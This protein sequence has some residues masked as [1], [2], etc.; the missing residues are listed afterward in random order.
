MKECLALVFAIQKTRYYLVGQTIHVIF[1][2]NP[3]CIL[4]TKLG[5][6]TSRLAK[7]AIL[8]S[9]YDIRFVPQKAVKAQALPDFLKAHL[10]SETSKLRKDIPD[11][12]F[13]SNMISEDEVWPIF[14][15]GASRIG[16]KGKIIAGGGYFSHHKIM[17]FL[18]HFHWQHLVLTM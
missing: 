2:V 7:W 17:S 9:Q 11:E 4:I 15:N 1:R 10:V 3:W 18:G 5:S 14:F 13:E 12:I 8:L 16:P 6:L